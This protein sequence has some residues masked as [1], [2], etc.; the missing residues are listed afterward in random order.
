MNSIEKKGESSPL[1]SLFEL[2]DPKT[3]AATEN[4]SIFEQLLQQKGIEEIKPE[5]FENMNIE[6]SDLLVPEN[7]LQKG[8]KEELSVEG[9]KISQE[10]METLLTM[11]SQIALTVQQPIVKDD[12]AAPEAKGEQLNIELTTKDTK[13]SSY[14]SNIA[15]FQDMKTIQSLKETLKELL[16]EVTESKRDTSAADTTLS[17]EVT[18]EASAVK[19]PV[20]VQVEVESTDLEKEVTK[21]VQDFVGNK[22]INSKH[23]EIIVNPKHLGE[24]H[25]KMTHTEQGIEIQVEVTN[26]EVKEHVEHLLSEAKKDLT[27]KGIDIQYQ[28]QDNRDNESQKRKEQ[29]DYKPKTI[30]ED[31]NEDTT[32]NELFQEEIGV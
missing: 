11:M 6:I 7:T 18:A 9:D 23:V 21:Q 3:V 16:N 1:G 19:T 5:S 10:A 32:F 2:L 8:E 27:E 28:V 14:T 15:M 31:T 12:S 20:M 26:P 29:Q 24:V 4:G 17:G 25:L 30:D 13:T 22:T